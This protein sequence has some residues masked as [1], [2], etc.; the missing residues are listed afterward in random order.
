MGLVRRVGG[1]QLSQLEPRPGKWDLLL[2]RNVGQWRRD[3]WMCMGLLLQ[4]PRKMPACRMA[5]S[6]NYPHAL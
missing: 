6:N 4:R 1:Q 5:R 3:V 2:L